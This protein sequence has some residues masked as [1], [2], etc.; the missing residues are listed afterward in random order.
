M[1][2]T[3]VAA[4]VL[5]ALG[6][7]RIVTAYNVFNH[8]IDEPDHLAAGMEYLHTGRYRYEDQHPPL[9]RVFA[10]IL[11]S[12]AGETFQPGPAIDTRALPARCSARFP[13]PH[14]RRCWPTSV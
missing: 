12:L 6:P 8:T 3:A 4:L 14:S 9:A 13:S 5:V 1:K 11:P 7:L 2:A 10:A